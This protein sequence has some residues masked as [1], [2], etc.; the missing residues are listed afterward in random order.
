MRPI[1][2][3][4]IAVAASAAL[5]IAFALAA[6]VGVRDASATFDEPVHAIASAALWQAGDYR[7]NPEHPPLWQYFAGLLA[8]GARPVIDPTSPAWRDLPRELT[9][10]WQYS[11][12]QLYRTPGF[13]ADRYLLRL[14]LTML[15][16]GVALG[17]AGAVW[18]WQLRR[19]AV[20]P[21]VACAAFALDP[22]FQA[23]AALVTNDVPLALAMFLAA[24]AAWCVGRR[25][26][27]GRVAWLAIACGLMPCMKYTG[28]LG[29]PLVL[30]LLLSRAAMPEGWR[31][32]RL[33]LTTRAQRFVAAGVIWLAVALSCYAMFW[34]SYR[35]RYDPT[36]DGSAVRLNTADVVTRIAEKD[37][38]GRRDGG[39]LVRGL[40]FADR[41][42]LLPQAM[43]AGL[44]YSKMISL[45]NSAFLLGEH[46]RGG[47]WS[48]FPLAML[49]KTPLATLVA[50]AAV[51]VGRF[52][53]VWRDAPAVADRWSI[54]CLIVPVAGYG[55]FAVSARLNIGLRHV[56]PLYPFL[57]VALGLAADA[58]W[59]G[60]RRLGL[61]A[62][63][64]LLIGLAIESLA[65]APHQL[66]FF[67]VACGGWRGGVR[68]LGDSNLDWGQDLKRLARWQRAH[69]DVPLFL[70]YF[71]TADPQYYGIRYANLPGGY[72]W[73]PR[74]QWPNGRGVLAISATNRQGIFLPPALKSAYGELARA[75]PIGV[76]G[77]TIYLYEFPLQRA[78]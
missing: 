74:Q 78:D 52:A 72:A 29:P 49:F 3:T 28:L 42:R 58:L 33:E 5:L 25:V 61:V 60:R 16:L 35:F 40:L 37:S 27:A 23:H 63:P 21:V 62:L 6:Y 18:A 19:G 54:A 22:N 1:S 26:T 7:V 17:A 36:P 48:Y 69:A 30:V 50:L 15:A 13:D 2:S 73:G 32:L 9:G 31:V 56:L 70:C 11:I 75:K 53:L 71:G 68:L 66:S 57:Y 8:G 59:R 76:V 45:G 4:A 43:V 10:H 65:S 67:N 34:A 24:H 39:L 55:L 47:W 12:D 14:R 51:P 20:A 77:T 64:A 38:D 44:I 46:S 41:H